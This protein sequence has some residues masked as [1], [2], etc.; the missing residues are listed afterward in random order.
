M[1]HPWIPKHQQVLVHLVSRS[2]Y[3]KF[4]QHRHLHL[5]LL[6]VVFVADSLPLHSLLLLL[7]LLTFSESINVQRYVSGMYSLTNTVQKIPFYVTFNFNVEKNLENLLI[8]S[9]KA[10]N[11]N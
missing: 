6:F 1:V 9:R 10:K 8:S 3:L 11:G 5:L 7:L 2:S 4:V